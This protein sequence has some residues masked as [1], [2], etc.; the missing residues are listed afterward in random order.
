M[1]IITGSARNIGSPRAIE[2]ARARTSVIV[3]Y[4]SS[5]NLCHQVKEIEENR[6][7]AA[8]TMG[9]TGE[10]QLA[11]LFINIAVDGSP[12]LDIIINNT[13]VRLNLLLSEG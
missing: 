3:N 9:N 1:A 7:G 5:E 6:G 13:A 11:N 10:A 8:N 2:L 4:R 12:A